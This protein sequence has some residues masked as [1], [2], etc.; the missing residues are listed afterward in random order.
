MFDILVLRIKLMFKFVFQDL[1][2]QFVRVKL[3]VFDLVC[4]LPVWQP[5][6]VNCVAVMCG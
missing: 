3:G 4:G 5:V 1:H 2:F 6:W